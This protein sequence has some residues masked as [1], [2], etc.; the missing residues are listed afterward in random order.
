[1]ILRASNIEELIAE[2]TEQAARMRDARYPSVDGERAAHTMAD[3]LEDVARAITLAPIAKAKV[4]N[5][6]HQEAK[7][8]EALAMVS[9]HMDEVS[10][11]IQKAHTRV[12]DAMLH[13]LE[14][15]SSI[16]G[17]DDHC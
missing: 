13:I 3:T 7:A 5:T 2:L 6:S 15:L 14:G 8:R 16:G 11:T 17:E 12:S 9:E 1:M 10:H 4:I